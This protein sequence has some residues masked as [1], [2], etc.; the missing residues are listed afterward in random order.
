MLREEIVWELHDPEDMERA[1]EIYGLVDQVWFVSVTPRAIAIVVGIALFF[2]SLSHNGR[3]PWWL[4]MIV[5]PI[6][7]GWVV[8]EF[9]W[10]AGFGNT[11]KKLVAKLEAL[12]GSGSGYAMVLTELTSKDPALNRFL[13]KHLPI[14]V[15]EDV[16]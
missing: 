1:D 15:N 6:F 11:R 3:W 7:G 2:F 9:A 5:F 10:V 14:Y 16:D 8:M 12:L 4:A 13:Q